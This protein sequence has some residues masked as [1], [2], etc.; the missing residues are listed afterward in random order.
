MS[1]AMVMIGVFMISRNE[2]NAPSPLRTPTDVPSSLSAAI[3][4]LVVEAGTLPAVV[5][6]LDPAT[7]RAGLQLYRSPRSGVPP[8][9]SACCACRTH[10]ARG[11]RTYSARVHQTEHLGDDVRGVVLPITGK[12]EIGRGWNA[13]ISARCGV[14]NPR[15]GKSG[16]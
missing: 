13:L 16:L 12:L 8:R 14:F 5:L 9:A 11:R 7:C 4:R 10:S 2:P 3:T 15:T 6:A 1:L